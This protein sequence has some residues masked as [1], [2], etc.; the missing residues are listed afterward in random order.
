[1]D[2]SQCT[3]FPVVMPVLS[4]VLCVWGLGL[5]ARLCYA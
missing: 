4:I 2:M 1:M 3:T 5:D